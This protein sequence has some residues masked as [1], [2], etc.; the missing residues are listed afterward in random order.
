MSRRSFARLTLLTVALAV[1]M[2]G[3]VARAACVWSFNWYCPNCAKIGGRTTG[4][5]SGYPTESA[6][7]S[8]RGS[9]ARGVTTGS[10]T[11]SG[12]CELPATPPQSYPGARPVPPTGGYTVPGYDYDAERQRAEE[13]RVRLEAEEADRQ[14]RQ[15]AE[16]EKRQRQFLQD[17]LDGLKSLKGGVDFDGGTRLKTGGESLGLKGTAGDD[18]GLKPL[19]SPEPTEKESRF[20]KGTRFSAPVYAI[21]EDASGRI[22]AKSGA[23]LGLIPDGNIGGFVAG[24]SWSPAVK[25][26]AFVGLVALER[27]P[28][29]RA[30]RI[31]Q[32]ASSGAPNDPFLKKAAGEADKLAK[33]RMEEIRPGSYVSHLPPELRA[34]YELGSED[35]DSGNMNGA[36]RFFG[37]V[38]KADPNNEALQILVRSVEKLRQ[39]ITPQDNQRIEKNRARA[40]SNAAFVLG[41]NAATNVAGF[42]KAVALRYLQ[43]AK[44]ISPDKDGSGFIDQ[45]QQRLR[46]GRPIGWPPS[47]YPLSRGDAILD[48]LEYGKGSWNDSLR[49]LK[50]L[51]AVQPG[52]KAVVAAHEELQSLHKESQR[53]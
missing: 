16:E 11:R 12:I 32:H 49:Y 42:D 3:A 6:C 1:V 45:F 27:G 38:L 24:Q 35:Y 29:G 26:I 2:Y 20:S 28:S 44:K 52:N 50:D 8:A 13:E 34:A 14:A 9:V 19:P 7:E 43:E 40:K 33:Q 5:Q 41:L 51:R 21:D 22:K 36:A 23:V 53:Q 4:N 15:K 25:G 17:K 18:L 39:P 30:A 31:L 37:R 46:E 47:N 48:A 10:C